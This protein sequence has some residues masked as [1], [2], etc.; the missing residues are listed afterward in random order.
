MIKTN[1]IKTLNKQ[2][3]VE[4]VKKKK[5]KKKKKKTYYTINFQKYWPT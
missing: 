3:K 5:K 1:K 2:N 4:Y